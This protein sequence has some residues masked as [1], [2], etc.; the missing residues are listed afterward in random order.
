MT[1]SNTEANLD[2]SAFVGSVLDGSYRVTRLIAEGGMGAVYQAIHLRLNKPVAIK[3]LA[4]QI[5]SNDEALARFRR[6][7]E[8]TSRLGH[9]HLV[10]VIDFGSSESGEPYLVMECLNGE[11]LDQRLRRVGRLPLAA[12]VE[13]TKQAASALA[14]AHVEGVVHRDLKPANL[15]LVSI[16][17]ED[18]F[19]KILDFGVSKIKAARTKLTRA[20]SVIGTPDYMSPEQATGLVDEID[21]RTDQWALG[22]IAWEMLAGRAPFMADDVTAL[23]YQIIHMDPHPLSKWVAGLPSGVEPVLRRALAKQSTERFP[24]IKDFAR[25]LDAAAAAASSPQAPSEPSSETA[26]LTPLQR[27]ETVTLPEWPESARDTLVVPEVRVPTAV[28]EDAATSAR[29]ELRPDTVVE[30][31][32]GKAARAR[33]GA[34]YLI[35]GAIIVVLIGI[36][37]VLR[38]RQAARLPS[39]GS[40]QA[41]SAK[42]SKKANAVVPVPESVP[43]LAPAVPSEPARPLD[44]ALDPAPAPREEAMPSAGTAAASPG[45]PPAQETSQTASSAKVKTAK[46][47]KPKTRAADPFEDLKAP[48][49]QPKRPIIEEL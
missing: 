48:H 30:A 14:A 25:A 7:A 16:P 6:E 38:T 37:L 21:H 23:F 4:R 17:G 32:A 42:D 15:F 35:A 2:A 5:A 36:V 47:G 43:V 33:S 3:I 46:S 41:T 24:T 26:T 10:Q 11:D 20:S 1:S 40:A 45:S 18:D 28:L 13:I 31:P 22:C 9:P 49:A 39:P 34:R 27:T 29:A 12:V 8:V 19:V 44:P